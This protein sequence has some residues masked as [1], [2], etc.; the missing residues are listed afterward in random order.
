MSSMV[1]Q[2]TWKHLAF[3]FNSFVFWSNKVHWHLL[4]AVPSIIFQHCFRSWPSAESA[5]GHYLNQ[6]GPS[7]QTHI[8]I[9]QPRWVNWCCITGELWSLM[10]TS[11]IFLKMAYPQSRDRVHCAC[12]MLQ[13][14]KTDLCS[15]FIITELHAVLCHIEPC[16]DATQLYVTITCDSGMTQCNHWLER[17]M[18]TG[19]S[20]VHQTHQNQCRWVICE[21]GVMKLH[22]G[23][24]EISIKMRWVHDTG[25]VLP[26]L[27]LW[28]EIMWWSRETVAWPSATID[29]ND[30]C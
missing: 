16:H 6:W 25:W 22:R 10:T 29:W 30:A 2:I 21:D 7:L 5:T 20:F 8:C 27:L 13:E 18:L 3:S 24:T 17:C 14:F 4:Q 12:M 26:H 28:Y 19:V 9:N 11:Q 15:A 1:S 23:R